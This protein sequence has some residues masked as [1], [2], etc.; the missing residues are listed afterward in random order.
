MN[1]YLF[2]IIF[3]LRYLGLIL[4]KIA[5]EELDEL[6][7]KI[8]ISIYILRGVF[9]GIVL[10]VFLNTFI[11][12]LTIGVVLVYSILHY[13]KTWSIFPY[14]DIFV[15]GLMFI[16]ISLFTSNMVLIIALMVIVLMLDVVVDKE[17][18]LKDELVYGGLYLVNLIGLIF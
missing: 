13:T 8:K 7:Y 11:F 2:I 15:T 18:K 10:G 4:K 12:Y 9:L 5:K 3:F 1:Y 16:L 14:F 6:H 17:F